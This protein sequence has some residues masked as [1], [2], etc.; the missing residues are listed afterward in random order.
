MSRGLYKDTMLTSLRHLKSCTTINEELL[1]FPEIINYQMSKGKVSSVKVSYEKYWDEIVFAFIEK[2]LTHFTD[3]REFWYELSKFEF[4]QGSATGRRFLKK[5]KSKVHL[6]SNLM[7]YGRG[8]VEIDSVPIVD[9]LYCGQVEK[10]SLRVVNALRREI[11]SDLLRPPTCSSTPAIFDLGSGWGRNS[12]LLADKFPNYSIYAGELTESG[13]K[14][15]Q[16]ISDHFS[17]NINPFPFDYMDWSELIRLVSETTHSEYLIFSNH[18]IEQVTYLSGKMFEQILETGKRLKFIHI[19]PVG[20]Q[21]E[22]AMGTVINTPPSGYKMH[23]NKN[24]LFL[25]DYLQKSEQIVDLLVYPDYVSF[26]NIANCG[27][28]IRYTSP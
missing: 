16:N 23:Y 27:S 18:S 3:P 4:L 1:I 26:G 19:E 8:Q 20:W 24:F 2:N 7:K 21:L 13:R 12:V 14:S 9:F 22:R 6:L 5:Q 25:L 15:L 10:V 28:L 11:Y 17:L